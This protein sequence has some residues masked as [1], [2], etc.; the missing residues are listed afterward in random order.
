MNDVI[1]MVLNHRSIRSYLDKPLTE[2]QIKIIVQSA[3]AAATS[4]YVQAYSIIGIKNQLQKDKLAELAGNQA[5]VAKNGHFFVFCL[6][7]HRLEIAAEIEGAK[8]ETI[9]L[10]LNSTEMFMIGLIDTALAAQNAAIAAESMGLGICYIGGL[11]NQLKAVTE[12]LQLPKR[13]I[14][15]FGLSVGYPANLS[16][17]KPRLPLLSVYHDDGYNQDKE[18]LMEYLH[19][20]DQEISNYYSERTQG[21][22][23]ER[24]TE[25][26]T[27]LLQNPKRLEMKQF[28]KD[29]KI[30]LE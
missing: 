3:Q 16:D 8:P 4:S 21:A 14:P 5:Y 25:A 28:L 10:T 9:E 18:Q 2:E 30:P 22:R 23:S 24:W 27:K 19:T 6:D 11:R 26:M 17:Q 29:N 7:L 13:V 12:L 20:Y 1:K 15:L